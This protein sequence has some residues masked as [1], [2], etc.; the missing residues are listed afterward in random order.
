M[1]DGFRFRI[2]TP[3]KKV[4]GNVRSFFSGHYQCCGVNVQAAVDHHSHFTYV[5]FAVPGVTQD[6][7]AI[8]HCSLFKLIE[9]LPPGVCAIG[10]AAHDP[11]EHVVPVYYAVDRRKPLFDNFNFYASQLCIRVEMAFGMMTRKWGVLQR[12]CTVNL[13]NA[14]KMVQAI[15]RL[16]NYVIAER[17]LECGTEQE[18]GPRRGQISYL[19]SVPEDENGNPVRLDALFTG[20]FECHSELRQRMAERVGRLQLTRPVS[21]RLKSNSNG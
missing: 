3:S 17:L 8:R 11:T 6:R 19:V 1:V 16:H 7:S 20:S 12:P 9:A 5:A 21:N 2:K 10:D 4:I 15:A 18:E 13:S 14:T